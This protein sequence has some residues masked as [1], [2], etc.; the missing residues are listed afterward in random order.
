MSSSFRMS[1]SFLASGLESWNKWFPR[2]RIPLYNPQYCKYP[3]KRGPEFWEPEEEVKGEEKLQGLGFGSLQV[4]YLGVQ[5]PP[6]V[7]GKRGADDE[8]SHR[9]EYLL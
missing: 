9:N 3:Q 4:S 5:N 8:E 1:R 6:V 7:F 2:I